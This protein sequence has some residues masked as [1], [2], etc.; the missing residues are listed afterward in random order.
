MSP[1]ELTERNAEIVARVARGGC[2]VASVA[3]EFGIS[4]GRACQIVAKHER[5]R[6]APPHFLGGLTARVRNAL[7]AQ[8]VR[9][10]EQVRQALVRHGSVGGRM[11]NVGRLGV[12]EIRAWLDDPI[13]R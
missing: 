8:D 11:Y 3:R 7:L 2:S 12:A 1:S 10:V 13:R 4:R 6:A 5:I 9:T